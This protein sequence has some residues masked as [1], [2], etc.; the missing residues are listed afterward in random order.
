MDFFFLPVIWILSSSVIMKTALLNWMKGIFNILT[1][2]RTR[3]CQVWVIL[4]WSRSLLMHHFS[5]KYFEHCLELST[6]KRLTWD[7]EHFPSWQF[8]SLFIYFTA[9][10]SLACLLLTWTQKVVTSPLIASSSSFMCMW[11]ALRRAQFLFMLCCSCLEI[12]HPFL[13]KGTWCLHFLLCSA[14]YVVSPSGLT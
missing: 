6:K 5:E 10:V 4:L 2:C 12:L 8:V 13:E 11:C 1:T 9:F 7:L 14:D 3:S